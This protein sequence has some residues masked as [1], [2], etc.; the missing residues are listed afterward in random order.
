MIINCCFNN[1][2]QFFLLLQMYLTADVSTPES[3]KIEIPLKK[4]KNIGCLLCYKHLKNAA[5]QLLHCTETKLL[6]TTRSYFSKDTYNFCFFTPLFMTW[7]NEAEPNQQCPTLLALLLLE[8]E[9]LALFF[10]VTF[11]YANNT[12]GE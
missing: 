6:Y 8:L 5:L 2:C 12:F 10:G 1:Y 9:T 7:L 4:G 3:F 11:L